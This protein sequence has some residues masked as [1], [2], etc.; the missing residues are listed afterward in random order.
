MYVLQIAR[1]LTHVIAEPGATAQ[2]AGLPVPYLK[3]FFRAFQLDDTDFRRRKI[4][5]IEP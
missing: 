3:E 2:R 1:F 4:W 5:I